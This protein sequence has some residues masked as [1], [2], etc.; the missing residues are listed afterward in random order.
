MFKFLLKITL[1][2]HDNRRQN[3]LFTR[4]KINVTNTNTENNVTS[5]V[6]FYT[7]FLFNY[8]KNPKHKR[9]FLIVNEQMSN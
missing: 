2:A 7:D 9:K 8:T 1:N 4:Y 5:N 3:L 6:M